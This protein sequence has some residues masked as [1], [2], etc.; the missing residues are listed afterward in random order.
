FRRGDP[1][2]FRKAGHAGTLGVTAD[3]EEIKEQHMNSISRRQSI[4]ALVSQRP[5]LFLHLAGIVLLLGLAFLPAAAQ[6]TTGSIVGD[7]LDQSGA[8]VDTAKV[9]ATNVDTGFTR[10]AQVNGDG[11]FRIDYLPVGKY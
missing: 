4:V 3:Q 6:Q 1:Q 10:T 11:Q 7:V 2:R 8:V 9:K 5:K